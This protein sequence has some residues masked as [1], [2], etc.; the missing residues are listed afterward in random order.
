MASASPGWG[1][2]FWRSPRAGF[3]PVGT[4]FKSLALF[5]G[6]CPGSVACTALVRRPLSP[7]EAVPFV[8]ETMDDL[9]NKGAADRNRIN[10]QEPWEVDHWTWLLGVSKDELQKVIKKVGNSAEAVRKELGRQMVHGQ[11]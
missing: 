7:A 5:S 3:V 11:H 8:E 10:L 9:K 4:T 2:F 6:P 1:R